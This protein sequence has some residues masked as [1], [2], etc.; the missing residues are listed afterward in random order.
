MC[1]IVGYVGQRP[2]C[3][4]VVDALRRMEYRGYDSAGVALLDGRGGLT[5]RRKAGRL[6]NL[7]AALAE[8]GTDNLVGA[9]G[10]GH[11][12]WATHGRPTDRNAHPHRD[13]SGKVAV[14][15]N[16]IIEN[17]AVLRAELE[18]A[19]VEFASDTD[20]EVTVHLVARE[21][22][23][24]ETAGDFPA[25]VLAVL[26]R[27][28]GH[29][30]LVFAHAD[31]PGTIVAARRSTP[32]VLGVGD[33]EMFVGSDVAAFIEHTRDAVEL[34]QDQA[35]V[36]TADGYRVT[37]FHGNPDDARTRRFHID[38]DT[39]A[40]EKGG[41]EYFMLKE[42]AEQ[43]AAVSDTLLGH[44]ADNRIVLDE[45]RLSDQELRDI[46]KV[47]VVACGTAYHS[48]LLAKYAIEHW[49]RLPVEVELASEFR[50]RDPVLD[51]HTLV[52]AISQSGETADTLEAVRHAK[53]QKAKVLAICN[54]N[55]SQIPRE[56]D[57]VLYTRAGPEIGVASTKTF[58]A[59]IAANYLVGLAL[60]QARGTKYPDEVAR[61][62]HDLEAMPDLIARVLDTS[63]PVLQ[64]AKQ[65][66]ASQTVLFLGRHVGYPVALEGALKLKELA[67][68]HAEGFA[69]GELKHGPIALIEDDLPV[70][71]VM[72]SPKN[73]A[74]LHSKLLSNIREIQ[75]R[76]A[77]T[78][79]IAE[80]G[81]DTVRPY[82]DHLIEIPAVSTLFQPLL[83]TI[84]MQLFSAGVAQARGYDVDKPRNLAKSV[85]VE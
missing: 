60:A 23:H 73:S 36:V 46:D 38:W 71:V 78:I 49:T 75:A 45:Q 83:S 18:A 50:Y 64:L 26:R 21:Y 58:L 56:C 39:S 65:F 42:I 22:V 80:E 69:A 61:E 67:Y 55:G 53:E 20:T 54:T 79:V 10:L 7:E 63:E 13:A 24:G 85:T 32:L 37:D 41:Y 14:V 74:T 29:F 16:G 43:P 44:F 62:Y 8:G 68:M 33:G 9:T 77:V 27:L 81:D 1:G 2:A 15:H 4:I 11:T 30:T 82:A 52:V 25:S 51:S 70:I 19:G 40:A 5:V 34:G 57:A 72:P 59:Q 84:P 47:F 6:A 35:V 12:R 28:E 76:G 66:A 17:F 31:D 48:G 3:D